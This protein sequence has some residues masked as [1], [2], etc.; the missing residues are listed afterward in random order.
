[1]AYN[2][3]ILG[4]VVV[5]A[6]IAGWLVVSLAGRR[7]LDPEDVDRGLADLAEALRSDRAIEA[8]VLPPPIHRTSR[9]STVQYR[10]AA[11]FWQSALTTA[12]K[13]PP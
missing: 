12:A 3:R 4:A 5:V 6:A 1:M 8:E 9:P 2:W 7:N 10:R 13:G 11:L